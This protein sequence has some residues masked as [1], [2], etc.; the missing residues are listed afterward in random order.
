[1]SCEPSPNAGED[2]RLETAL[3]NLSQNVVRLTKVV[4]FLHT[5][6]D[7][8]DARMA[9][10]KFFCEEEVRQVAQAAAAEVDKHQR[11]V[12][13]V[14]KKQ[15]CRR[16]EKQRQLTLLN[17]GADKAVE[18]FRRVYEHRERL[19]RQK[20]DDA[21]NSRSITIAGVRKQTLEFQRNLE[22]AEDRAR[23]DSRWLARQLAAE[24][25]R[26]RKS[27][28][29][30]FEEASSEL[31]RIHA[32]D[33]EKLKATRESIIEEQKVTQEFGRSEALVE[34]D[35]EASE[36]LERQSTDL[37]EQRRKLD[38]AARELRGK[39]DAA[40]HEAS[41]A[42]DRYAELQRELDEMSR[43]LQEKK[44]RSRVLSQDADRAHDRKLRAEG[45]IR[46]LRRR[47]AAIERSLGDLG[48]APQTEKALASLSEDV[49]AAQGRQEKLRQELDRRQR[50]A[51]ERGN[52]VV[53]NEQLVERLQKELKDEHARADELQRV[54]LRLESR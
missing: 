26:E 52:S 6:S 33:V 47:K 14:A 40:R 36:A 25:A 7:V 13:A 35:Q 42:K 46:E 23:N 44:K 18:E 37:S 19:Q 34:A 51:T 32:A 8:H 38:D 43:D 4:F 3:A 9:A 31:K 20:A 28:E 41:S 21:Q 15:E 10:L 1:M 29:Q 27:L 11:H 30:R 48:V 45:D 2:P 53:E 50:L 16:A 12:A 17:D 49:R 5:R 39:L 22:A 54:L 24:A